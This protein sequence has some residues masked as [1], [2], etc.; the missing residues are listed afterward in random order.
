MDHVVMKI[1]IELVYKIGVCELGGIH[2][3]YQKKL[4]DCIDKTRKWI[5]NKDYQRR[6]DEAKFPKYN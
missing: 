4:L 2:I 6:E 3:Y 1:M 5:W